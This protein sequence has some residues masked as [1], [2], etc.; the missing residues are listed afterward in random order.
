MTTTLPRED[1]AVAVSIVNYGTARMVLDALPALMEEL[2]RFTRSHVVIVDNCSPGDDG[3]RLEAGV[4]TLALAPSVEVIRSPVN[5]GFAAGNNVA[6]AAI[7]LLPWRPDGVFLLNPD[8]VATPGVLSALFAI[9]DAHPEAGFV[10]P[11]VDDPE[12]GSFSGAFRF[13]TLMTEVAKGLGIGALLRQFP[14][15][16]DETDAPVEVDWIT[17]SACLIRG[18]SVRGAR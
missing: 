9:F 16:I 8:A 17:G 14:T 11:R 15:V 18:R 7:R 13:P 4:A 5:G 6:F 12:G 10:G 1:R 2:A 3:A